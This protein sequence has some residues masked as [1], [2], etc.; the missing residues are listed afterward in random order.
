MRIVWTAEAVDDLDNILAYIASQDIGAAGLIAERVLKTEEYISEFPRSAPY[1]KQSDTYDR[2][3]P[4]TRIILTY[5][6]S[7][8]MVRVLSAWHTSRDPDER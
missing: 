2:Y 8:D 6:I 7:G 3:I 4:K 5:E 1:D